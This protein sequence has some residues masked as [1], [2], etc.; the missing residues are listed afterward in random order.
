MANTLKINSGYLKRS[1]IK[2]PKKAKPVKSIIKLSAFNWLAD[3]IK[4]KTVL[5]LFAG[6]GNL[7][8]EALS[9]GATHAVLVE[10]DYEAFKTIQENIVNLNLEN[11]CE[12]EHIDTLKYIGQAVETFDIVFADPPYNAP[13]KHFLKTVHIVVKP[14]GLLVYFHEK[15]SKIEEVENMTHVTTR[16]FGKSCY[17]VYKS[18]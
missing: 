17:T 10:E 3:N 18:I 2:V 12:V 6:S 11:K 5:D 15:S 4:D 1:N 7:A 14:E 16:E 8:F 9:I 13:N